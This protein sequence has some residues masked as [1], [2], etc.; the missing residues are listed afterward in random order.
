MVE[1]RFAAQCTNHDNNYEK[2]NIDFAEKR[3][4]SIAVEKEETEESFKN[5]LSSWTCMDRS[6]HV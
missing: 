3:A 1:C 6:G 5:D 4:D 2:H